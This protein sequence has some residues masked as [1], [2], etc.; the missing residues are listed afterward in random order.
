MLRINPVIE[1]RVRDHFKDNAIGEILKGFEQAREAL[2]EYDAEKELRLAKREKDEVEILA[3]HSANKGKK[4]K[5]DD[6]HS[7]YE[8]EDD[9]NNYDDL[10]S[11]IE[12]DIEGLADD[13]IKTPK[14][15]KLVNEQKAAEKENQFERPVFPGNMH[16]EKSPMFIFVDILLEFF[17]SIVFLQEEYMHLSNVLSEMI[18]RGSLTLIQRRQFIKPAKSTS[19][20]L[21]LKQ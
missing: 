2:R 14:K 9:E 16:P 21:G 8:Q 3:S 6:G 15:K 4:I 18:D 1:D 5:E 10:D 7:D 13:G 17:G 20:T 12:D 19:S 11:F